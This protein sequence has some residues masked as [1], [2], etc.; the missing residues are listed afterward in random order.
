MLTDHKLLKKMKKT[1]KPI[2]LSTGMSKMEQIKEAVDV[3]GG[4]DNLVIQHC[5]S[6]YPADPEELNLRA[7]VTLQE[8]FD[9]PIGYSGHETGLQTTYAAVALGA[10]TVERHITLDRTMWGSDQAASVEPFG[11]L[12]LVRDCKVVHKAL[13]DGKIKVHPNEI[14]PMKKLR[15]TDDTGKMKTIIDLYVND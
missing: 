7:I 3:L 14:P 8:E 10:C 4:T 15:K 11:L 9:C 12:R 1:D 13:G 6:T 5:V 2:I